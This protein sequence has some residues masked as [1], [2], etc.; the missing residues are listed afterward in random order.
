MNPCQKPKK[1]RIEG[2]SEPPGVPKKIQ[3]RPANPHRMGF[4]T[5]ISKNVLKSW[6]V[7]KWDDRERY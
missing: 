2:L 1:T 4:F 7:K 6:E 5:Q 3:K